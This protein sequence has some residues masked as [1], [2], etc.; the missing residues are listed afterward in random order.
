VA[1]HPPPGPRPFYRLLGMARPPP[2]Y[3]AGCSG[4]FR[5][6]PAPRTVGG[7]GSAGPT[8]PYGFPCSTWHPRVWG[9]TRFVDIT[10]LDQVVRAAIRPTTREI[11][12][13][14]ETIATRP[15]RPSRPA[16][17]PC[18]N[19]HRGRRGSSLVPSASNPWPRRSLPP[20]EHGADLVGHSATRNSAR[21]LALRPHRRPVVTRAPKIG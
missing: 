18:R 7:V 4:T 9:D 3:T 13:R 10:D 1:R 14:R 20:L 15:T 21:P 8:G 16:T 17:K 2:H 11:V 5:P 19:S 6:G 12:L